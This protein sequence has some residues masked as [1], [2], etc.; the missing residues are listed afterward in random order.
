MKVDIF[1]FELDRELIAT[2]PANP[3]DT[4]KLLDLSVEDKITDRHFYD[5]PQLLN[6]N[7]ILVFND[8]KV[9]PAKLYAIRGSAEVEITLYHPLGTTSW[10]S[11]IKNSKRLK[12]DDIITIYSANISAEKS[13]FKAKIMEKREDD[14]VRLEFLCPAEDFYHLLD[15]YGSMPLPPYI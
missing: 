8:T 12:Q 10:W 9:I 5:L 3:R 1:D 4:S 13:E 6:T 14:G 7:D 11:F 2:S 15:V